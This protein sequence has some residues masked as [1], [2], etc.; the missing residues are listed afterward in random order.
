MW[1]GKGKNLGDN[2][3]IPFLLLSKKNETTIR[4]N[5]YPYFLVTFVT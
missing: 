3:K 4:I 2:M 1:R 5:N